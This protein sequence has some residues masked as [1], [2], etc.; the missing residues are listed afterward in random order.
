MTGIYRIRNKINGKCYYGSSIN[1]K[2]RRL[3]H[4]NGLSKNKHENI[5]LQNAWNKYGSN[6]FEFEIVEE[7]NKDMLRDVE[8]TYID[9][10]PEYNIGKQST[11]GDNLSNNPNKVEIIE[12]IKKTN[13]KR[14]DN[15]TTEE[16]KEKF[17]MPMERNPNWKNGLT[18]LYCQCGK[19]ITYK[20]TYCNKCRPRTDNDNPFYGKNH[21]EKT[22]K[23]LSELKNGVYNGKQ[24]HSIIIDGVEYR[25]SGEA[26][27]LLGIPSITIR[28]RVLSKNP[29]YKNYQYKGKDTIFYTDEEQFERLSKP[30]RLKKTNTNRPFIIDNVEYRTLKEASGK[31]LIHFMTIKGRLK[32]ENFKNYE[33]KK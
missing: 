26:S 15:M 32:N 5:H 11:G 14:L 17:S 13:K 2:K 33:Y 22:K 6:C 28:W 23:Y 16:K 25:S 30:H 10:N 31:L 20:H 1:I 27:K 3:K 9:L 4:I 24:N 29:K 18:Y 7:C 12:R 8:Q 21:S 19:R